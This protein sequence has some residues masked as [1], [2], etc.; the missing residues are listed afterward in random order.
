MPVSGP[1]QRASQRAQRH[2]G[3]VTRQQILETACQLFAEQGYANTTS[4]QVC[5]NSRANVAS[6][7]Y[8]FQNKDGLYRAVLLEAH[9]RLIH[10]QTLLSL[11]QS[12]AAAQDKLRLVISLLVERLQNHRENWALRVL[13]REL[14][15]PSPVLPSVLEQKAFP[16]A[17]VLRSVLGQIMGLPDDHP[18]T[19]RSAL[20]VFTPCLFLLLAHDT[21]SNN[22]LP[23]LDTEPA[24][25]IDEMMIYALAGLKAVSAPE[26]G[27]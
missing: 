3:Q 22:V 26:R 17:K 21:L 14:L 13:S 4:K 27:R 10:L 24:A 11:S 16:K 15:S 5:E 19:L 18:T 20:M 2:D 12:Q 6:V 7:N 23:G 8:H 9:D 25:L 1:N